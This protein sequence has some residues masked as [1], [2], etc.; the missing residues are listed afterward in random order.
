LLGDGQSGQ[1]QE[2]G[3][4]LYAELLDRAVRALKSGKQPELDTSLHHGTEIELGVPSLIPE[5]YLPDIHTRLVFYKRIA[6]AKDTQSLRE[7]E[8]EMI[9]RF[10]LLPDQVKNLFAATSVKLLVEPMNLLKV[11]AHE[12]MIRI[13][14]GSSPNI[15]PL[16]LIQ[17]IQRQPKNYQLK[18]QTELKYFDTMPETAQRIQA[19]E[20]I[21]ASIKAG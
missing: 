20:L 7:L 3:F 1:I 14:F 21:V 18:G 17:L 5:D 16:R 8:V 19:I 13:Q 10:G 9:D 6:G 15:D 12:T 2:I 4:G 11:E